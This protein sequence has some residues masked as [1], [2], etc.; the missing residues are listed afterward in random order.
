MNFGE[1][2][3]HQAVSKEVGT[4]NFKKFNSISA[5]AILE[6]TSLASFLRG[7]GCGTRTA[8]CAMPDKI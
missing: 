4:I 8:A 5:C 3:D 7:D 2:K 1:T 6:I